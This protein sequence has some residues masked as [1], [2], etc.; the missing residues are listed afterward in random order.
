VIYAAP[1]VTSAK[2][3]DNIVRI[4]L[5]EPQ[6]RFC[7]S[8]KL[9]RALFGGRGAGKT[10]V[11]AYDMLKRAEPGGL[12]G[13]YAPTFRML[14]DATIRTFM[15][16]AL[17]FRFVKRLYKADKRV[18]LKNGAEILFRSLEIPEHARGP[19]LDGAWIDEASLVK[20]ECFEIIIAA[21]RNGGKMGW[22]SATFTPKGRKHWTYEVFVL[23]KFGVAEGI[24]APTTSNIFLAPE[25]VEIVRSHYTSSMA[26]QELDGQFIDL[27]GTIARREWFEIVP[28]RPSEVRRRA[29]CWDLSASSRSSSDGGSDWSVGTLLSI[30]KQGY[31]YVEDVVRGHWGPGTLE[32]I[33]R[34][35]AERDGSD[36]IIG[37]EQEPG[38]SGKL[39][40]GSIVRALPSYRVQPVPTWTGDKITRGMPFLAKAE[41]GFV[42][43]VQGH[44]NEEW[45]DEICSIPLAEHDDQF[46]S[47]VGAFWIVSTMLERRLYTW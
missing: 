40:V 26:A 2:P 31:I 22:L 6:M 11:G 9:Y 21:L 44:W 41:H 20:R 15:D 1:S 13:V 33:I 17:D 5:T 23:D 37:I 7:N 39:F 35:T 25:F 16:M 34:Q 42:R 30:D 10:F 29:R 38:S 47:V 24:R 19:N 32:E 43:L 28:F 46:D 14:Q 4:Q 27:D 18:L 45:L 12:Y 3:S 36:V 8:T